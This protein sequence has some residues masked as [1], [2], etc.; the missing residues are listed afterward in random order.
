[1]KNTDVLTARLNR[2]IHDLKDLDPDG[3]PGARNPFV[4][5]EWKADRDREARIN[6]HLDVGVHYILCRLRD[7]LDSYEVSY[8]VH[9]NRA[10]RRPSVELWVER[11][12][13]HSAPAS[14]DLSFV[15]QADEM[16]GLFSV[17]VF[18]GGRGDWHHSSCQYC[19]EGL[20]D[21]V[22][23]ELPT[24]LE[25]WIRA[26]AA[27]NSPTSISTEITSALLAIE[28]VLNDTEAFKAVRLDVE[29]RARKYKSFSNLVP[30][31]ADR[32][33][34]IQF[35]PRH[36][37]EVAG[38]TLLDQ[39]ARSRVWKTFLLGRDAFDE[40]FMRAVGEAKNSSEGK[41]AQTPASN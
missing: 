29:R 2:V 40:R 13:E 15:L 14:T 28:A 4:D 21:L 27:A 32:L 10:W 36:G 18:D 20:A 6:Q 7:K 38:E 22:I 34:R 11:N 37:I 25:S 17:L 23:A 12:D 9:W 30:S 31:Y 16:C 39:P 35:E 26:R 41:G 5:R 33:T 19:P 3:A 24:L 8:S 1:M